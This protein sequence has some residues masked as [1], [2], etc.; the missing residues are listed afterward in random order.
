VTTGITD[1]A[2]GP[3]FTKVTSREE[4]VAVESLSTEGP[5]SPD[6]EVIKKSHKI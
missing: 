1:V 5:A 3:E 2:V 6:P 4:S